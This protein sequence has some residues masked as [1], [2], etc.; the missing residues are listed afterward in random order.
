MSIKQLLVL[1][2]A[3]LVIQPVFANDDMSADEKPCINIVKSC[4]NGGYTEQAS[5]GKQF[6]KDCMEP[7]ILGKTVS[8]VT[9]DA[10]DVKACRTAKIKQLQQELGKLKAAK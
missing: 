8:G 3:A 9:V 1:S 2:A 6:W 4:L 5:E 7:L 10:N